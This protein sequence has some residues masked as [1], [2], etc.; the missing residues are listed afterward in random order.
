MGKDVF[1]GVIS[2]V[3][4][5]IGIAL[6]AVIVGQ[7]SQTATILKTGGSALASILQAAEAPA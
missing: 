5:V 1:Q 3:L 7:K 2:I 4:A 6:V